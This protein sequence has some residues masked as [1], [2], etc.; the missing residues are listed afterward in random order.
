M[1][2]IRKRRGQ[3][4]GRSKKKALRRISNNK[5]LFKPV[6]GTLGLRRP[7]RKL[8]KTVRPSLGG[9]RSKK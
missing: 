3:R 8:F 4:L 9:T 7:T 2:S 1:Q 5:T 6:F